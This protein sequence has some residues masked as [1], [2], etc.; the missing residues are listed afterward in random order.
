MFSSQITRSWASRLPS[1]HTVTLH[2][3]MHP[4]DQ[5]FGI[6]VTHYSL[7]RLCEYMV[8]MHIL[9]MQRFK[10]NQWIG[11]PGLHCAYALTSSKLVNCFDVLWYV[12]DVCHLIRRRPQQSAAAFQFSRVMLRLQN[13]FKFY[14]VWHVCVVCVICW[15]MLLGYSI[16]FKYVVCGIQCV[17]VKDVDNHCS[18]AI[19]L[20]ATKVEEVYI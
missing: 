9:L 17:C 6:L 5:P 18:W 11:Y 14:Y 19:S 20:T 16:I 8:Q 13:D 1:C 10:H 7:P 15:V 12:L 3:C 2:V 4:H